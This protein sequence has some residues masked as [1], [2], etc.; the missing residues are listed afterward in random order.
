MEEEKPARYDQQLMVPHLDY[1][2]GVT[3]IVCSVVAVVGNVIA[4]IIM[5]RICKKGNAKFSTI[6]F[7]NIA[8]VNLVGQHLLAICIKTN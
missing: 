7:L 8:V 1:F 3:L 4:V 2:L 5:G 6:I